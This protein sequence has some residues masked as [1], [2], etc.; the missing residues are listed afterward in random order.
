MK[1]KANDQDIFFGVQDQN[2]KLE[3]RTVEFWIPTIQPSLE[4]EAG[5]TKRLNSNKDI[6]V[7]ILKQNTFTTT[8]IQQKQ[9]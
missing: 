3:I 9:S 2:A 7:S 5:V 6:A 8:I 1:R 4:I